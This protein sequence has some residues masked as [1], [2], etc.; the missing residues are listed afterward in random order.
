MGKAG[1]E[2][3]LVR[4]DPRQQD[5]AVKRGDNR[6]QTVQHFNVV[7]EVHRLGTWHGKPT[8]YRLPKEDQEGLTSLILVQGNR[9]GRIVGVGLK[10]S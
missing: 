4:F 9:G 7:R 1:A 5:V 3:W 2:V 8:A 10:G 6:G